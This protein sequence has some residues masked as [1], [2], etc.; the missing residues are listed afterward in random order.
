MEGG[1][2]LCPH[3]H[4]G[5]AATR[6]G[7]AKYS[8]CIFW[9]TC[10]HQQ[11]KEG[12]WEEA[13]LS[14]HEGSDKGTEDSGRLCPPAKPGA[15]FPVS[16]QV[17]GGAEAVKGLSLAYSGGRWVGLLPGSLASLPQTTPASGLEKAGLWF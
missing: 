12:C 16:L 3:V 10:R 6:S 7:D 8:S 4:Q 1:R 11:G 9:A 5:F 17:W 13:C 14:N 15:V 2:E